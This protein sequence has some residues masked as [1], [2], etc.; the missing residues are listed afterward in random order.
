MLGVRWCSEQ[1]GKGDEQRTGKTGQVEG[2]LKSK[3]GFFS[4]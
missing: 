4:V 1:G 3:E 2:R